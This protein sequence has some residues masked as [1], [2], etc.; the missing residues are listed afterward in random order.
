MKLDSAAVDYTPGEAWAIAKRAED[1]GYDGFWLAETKHDPFLALAGAAAA[2]ERI[3]LGTAIAVAFARNPMTVATTAN[4]LQLLSGGRFNLGLGS[5]VEAHITKRFAMPWSRPAAR[6]R[7]FVLAIRAIWHAWETGERLAFRG[8][9]YKHTLMT[10]FFDP[11]PNPHGTAP[12]YL[13]G[14]GELMTEVAGEVADGFLCHNF[15]T[16]R[17]LREVTLPALD[18]GRAKVGKTLEGFEISGPVFAATNEQEIADVKRQIAFYGSTPAYRPVLDLHG[19]GALH[20]ELH[21]MSRRQQWAE[22]SE[23]ITDEVLAE[24]CVLGAPETVTAALLDR[25][26]DVVT[27]VSPSS[28]VLQRPEK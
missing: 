20:E 22:M 23:L 14:V 6:M 15:T 11:G 2:T 10:P 27:R 3:E 26:G 28:A 5:Q 25:Y 24:F 16:E 9:F 8:E 7:E 1:R 12:I 13:A 18:R 21:R 17:Y 4:D 19:W